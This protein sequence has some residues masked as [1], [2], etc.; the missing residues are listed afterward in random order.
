MLHHHI[1]D[2]G[3]GPDRL[4]G[5]P[6]R[7]HGRGHQG[8]APTRP[9]RSARRSAPRRRSPASPRRDGAVTGVV[10]ESGEEISAPTR[11]HHGP[12]ADLV[13][14]PARP[15][16]P[17]RR[18]R[19]RHRAL[20][21][22]QRHGEGQPRGRP[23]AGVHQPARLRP[24]GARRHDRAGR[25][26]RR[27]RGRVPGRGRPAAPRR[28]RSPTSAS[29]A[30]STTRSRRA[31]QHVVSMFTQW[32]P[33]TWSAEP[34]ARRA[35]GVRRPRDRPD[36]RGRARASPT[37]SCTARSSG[38]TRWSTSTAWSAATSSTAS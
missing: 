15:P 16:R 17:A 29:P 9:A 24:G 11:R 30:S 26:A 31:G 19:R 8:A 20:E 34:H 1:G 33:H 10:L 22:P 23:A 6:A 35:R 36:G 32:V 3:D 7:R 14:A 5:L 28:C 18:L 13:P 12:P 38:R 4:V 27:H 21:V 37:R 2:V 25:V